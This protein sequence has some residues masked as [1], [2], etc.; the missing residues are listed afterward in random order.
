MKKKYLKIAMFVLLVVGI[1]ISLN[2]SIRQGTCLA[3]LRLGNVEALTSP[4]A[5][6]PYDPCV[7][8]KGYCLIGGIKIKGIALPPE[9]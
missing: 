4:E 8:A 2:L 5:E 3:T 6:N 7:Y 1:A 9:K